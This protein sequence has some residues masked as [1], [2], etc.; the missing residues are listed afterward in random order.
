MP[1]YWYC[2]F[3]Y[4]LRVDG[5]KFKIIDTRLFCEFGKNKIIQE[6][7]VKEGDW[8]SVNKRA[9]GN[10][11][12]IQDPNLFTQHLRVTSSKLSHIMLIGK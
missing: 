11:A 10:I 3:R 4:W 6:R 12:L 8:D 1:T 5:V 7:I 9:H 2:L